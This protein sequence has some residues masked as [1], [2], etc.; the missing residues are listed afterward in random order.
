VSKWPMVRLGEIGKV[1]TGNTPPTSNTIYYESNDIQFYK[2][3]DFEESLVN[4]LNISTAFVSIKSQDKIRLLPR[5]SVLTTCIGT[6]GKVGVLNNIATCNQ[7][8]NA[9]IP[10]QN[11]INE[12]Y[13][14]YS[15]FSKRKYLNEIANAPVVPIVNKTQFSNIE[16]SLPSLE[17]QKKIAQ[18]LDAAAELTALR[19]RQLAELDNLVKAVFYD[20]FGDPE[21]NPNGWPEKLLDSMADITSGVTKGRKLENRSIIS[22][23]YMRVANVQDG[24]LVLNEVKEIEILPSDL[25]KYRLLS[26]D[27]LMTEGGDPDKL[28]RCAIWNNE[29]PNCIHQNHIFRV[30]LDQRLASPTYVCFLTGSQYGKKYFLHA[31][32]QTTGIATINSRQLKQFPVL[33]P[34]ISLQN[35]FAAVVEK[36]EEQKA[37]VQ[38]AIDESQ[39]LFDSLMGEYFD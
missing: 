14:A 4:K 5:G 32:K 18:T 29:I 16:I 25:E 26:D 19:K 20:M 28:G 30:R 39:Y 31:A 24:H 35:Q 8:I 38:K 23:P 11:I 13:L 17:V 33:L 1:L 12:D 6:I 22:V 10:D 2:P 27:L 21:Q 37:L 9:I 36:V 7:Q 34:P 15:I 3:N